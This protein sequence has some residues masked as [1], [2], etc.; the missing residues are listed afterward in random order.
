MSTNQTQCDLELDLQNSDAVQQHKFMAHFGAYMQLAAYEDDLDEYFA[1]LF[2]LWFLL[3]P[4]A[5][6]E[7]KIAVRHLKI[8]II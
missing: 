5:D 7:V 4:H 6:Q 8:F 1:R 3:W 2:R